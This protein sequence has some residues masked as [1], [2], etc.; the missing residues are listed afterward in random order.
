MIGEPQPSY[1]EE[2]I[3]NKTRRYLLGNVIKKYLLNQFTLLTNFWSNQNNAAQSIVSRP[4][5]A[6]VNVIFRMRVR[7][8]F[9]V[10]F[11]NSHFL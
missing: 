4:S 11:S 8:P 2:S 5:P 6:A 1:T 9:N 3:K 7:S 10:S